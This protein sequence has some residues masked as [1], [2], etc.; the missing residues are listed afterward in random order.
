MMMKL[1]LLVLVWGASARIGTR[2]LE[3]SFVDDTEAEQLDAKENEAKAALAA[4]V[5][6]MFTLN[7]RT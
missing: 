1:C 3:V 2:R 5:S 4:E 7:E 6:S